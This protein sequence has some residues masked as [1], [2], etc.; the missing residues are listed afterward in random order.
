MPYVS[1]AQRRLLH[2]RHPRLAAR[3]DREYGTPKNL[4]YHKKRKR[5]LHAAMSRISR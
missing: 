3:W 5:P 1:E 4:P 2:A